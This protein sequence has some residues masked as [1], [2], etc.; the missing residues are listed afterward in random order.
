MLYLLLI[1]R[2]SRLRPTVLLQCESTNT[3]TVAWH[4]A[5]VAMFFNF[6]F[7]ILYLFAIPY[8]TVKGLFSVYVH[9]RTLHMVLMESWQSCGFKLNDCLS[10][11]LYPQSKDL[12]ERV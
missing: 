12:E 3:D 4:S 2:L 7:K 9:I 6:I 8:F 11:S 1:V 10:P 5:Q